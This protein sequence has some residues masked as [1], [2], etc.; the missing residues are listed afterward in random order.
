MEHTSFAPLTIVTLV[1]FDKKAEEKIE[2]K[3]IIMAIGDF[4][5]A[6]TSWAIIRSIAFTGNLDVKEVRERTLEI[7]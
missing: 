2:L 6:N 7:D 4:S 1:Y 5:V 3:E